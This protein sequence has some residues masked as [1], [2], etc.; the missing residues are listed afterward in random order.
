MKILIRVDGKILGFQEH[1]SVDAAADA[2]PQYVLRSCYYT[3]QYAV[4]D[5]ISNENTEMEDAVAE[6]LEAGRKLSNVWV[7]QKVKQY[8]D[9]LPS[10]D[11]FLTEFSSLLEEPPV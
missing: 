11:E 4:A 1:A 10:F 9:Y 2:Y 8:P 7:E 3:G 6:F 5:L